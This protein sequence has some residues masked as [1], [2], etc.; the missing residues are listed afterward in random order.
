MIELL[1]IYNIYSYNNENK[2]FIY[3]TIKKTQK[4]IFIVTYTK[5]RKMFQLFGV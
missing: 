4:I 3:L 2:I 5:Y 1:F